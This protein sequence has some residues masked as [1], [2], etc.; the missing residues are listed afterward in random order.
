MGFPLAAYSEILL[1]LQILDA[2]PP[3][4]ID[5]DLVQSGKLDAIPKPATGATPATALPAESGRRAPA[6]AVDA[7][8]KPA[9]RPLDLEP[10][11]SEGAARPAKKLSS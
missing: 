9:Q 11:R 2:P 3:V 1:L 5:S 6:G 10:D 8:G 7:V 4:D